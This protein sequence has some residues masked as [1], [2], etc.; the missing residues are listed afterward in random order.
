MTELDFEAANLG[1]LANISGTLSE[2][3]HT[4]VGSERDGTALLL[5]LAAGITQASS[6]RVTLDGVP[7]GSDAPI[8]RR[9][10]TL[11]ADETLPPGRNVKGSLELALQARGDAR[12]AFS[13]LDAAG[14]T[15]FAARR[16][17]SLGAREQRAVALALALSHPDPKLAV[18]HEP[19]SLVGI[20][21]EEYLLGALQRMGE[22]GT[23]VLCT[24]NRVQDATRLGG[25]VSALERGLWLDSPEARRGLTRITVRVHAS[26]PQRL[27]ECVARA[28]EISGAHW[29][30][31]HEV[32]VYGSHFE[33]IAR[34]IVVSARAAAV[35]ILA[36][37]QDAPALEALAAARAGLYDA[38]SDVAVRVLS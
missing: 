19:L 37:K 30:G 26:E 28:P 23:V 18:L 1:L 36:L 5:Q 4:V 9:T 7:P 11:C 34:A 21:S 25:E 27:L 15:E 3:C 20:V 24:A 29:L 33:Q 22:A 31:G 2:G 14:L 12:S 38:R 35:Q 16:V 17:S 6:G 13:V 32:L 10:A 8:R